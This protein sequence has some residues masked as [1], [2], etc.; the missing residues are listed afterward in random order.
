MVFWEFLE[1]LTD[2]H[3]FLS[4]RDRNLTAALTA[5]HPFHQAGLTPFLLQDPPAPAA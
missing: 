1:S 2:C 3:S 4:M 5:D